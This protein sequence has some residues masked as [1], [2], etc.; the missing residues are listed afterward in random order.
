M[1]LIGLDVG[2]KRIG[3]AV[4]DSGVRIA[5]P[6]TTINVKNGAE[7][8]EIA[9][10]ARQNN[11]N[12]FVIGMP[13]SNN[14][15]K[16]AQSSYVENFAKTLSEAIPGAKIR[17]QDESLTSVEAENRLKSRKKTYAKE[18]IDAEAAAIILQD[19]IEHLSVTSKGSTATEH[20]V[21]TADFDANISQA[22][23]EKKGNSMLKKFVIILLAIL[24]AGGVG[25]VVV[26]SWYNSSLGPVYQVADCGELKDD[27]RCDFIDFS[28]T[29]GE[30]IQIIGDNLES[31]GIIKSS[32]AFQIFM[33]T[34]HLADQVKVGEYQFRRTMDVE[35]IGNQ[36]KE[37]AKNPNVFSFTILPGSTIREIK[38]SL[39]KQGYSTAE[40]EAAFSKN[41]DSPVLQSLPASTEQG[42]ERLEGYLFGDTYEFYKTDSVET[43]IQTALDAMWKV[44]EGNNLIAQFSSHG[45]SLHQGITLASI[46]Q[47]EASNYEDQRKV[48]QVFYS[49]ISQGTTLGSDVTATYAADLL[50]PNRE[51]YKDN[52]AILEIDSPYNTRKNRGLPP[53][54]IDNPGT[55]ALL[56]AATPTDTS[57]LYFLT[58]DDG[59]MY[60]SYTDSEH[61]QN[62]IDHCRNLCNV[63]L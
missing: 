8:S 49:R 17:F 10:L 30:N 27:P 6:T 18:E 59:V 21:S 4:A 44:V 62:I 45:L 7:F 50:D 46:I 24:L 16:T 22:K 61:N 12:W 34:H 38:A 55:S 20:F 3:V 43:I 23:S 48:A 32:L 14:G 37:G 63:S 11:T 51:I 33:R 58:G 39:I 40:V 31:A 60:Y 52:A 29:Q 54:P 56:A 5:V 41:Y 25:A 53:G 13:R 57:Y 26:Y 47:K 36:L 19:C 1:K 15:N 9:H 2:T 35:E 28:V 42:A